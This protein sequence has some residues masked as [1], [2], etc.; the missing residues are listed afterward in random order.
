MTSQKKITVIIADDHTL[1]RRGL[2]TLLS[3]NKDVEVIAEVGDGRVAIDMTMEMQPDVVMMDLSMPNLSGFEAIRQI[4]RKAP[5]V[6]ILVLSA[7]DNEEY[8]LETIQSGADG[9]MLKDTSPGELNTAL[10]TVSSGRPYYSPAIARIAE[11]AKTAAASSFGARGSS[12]ADRLTE[13][14]REILQLI[15]ESRSHQQIAEMLHISVRTV[16]THRNNIIQKLGLHDTASLV[17]FA[18]KNGIIIL[19]R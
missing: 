1:V 7:Y 14:E 11:E 16:D 8:V 19:P 10:K 6:K 15:A 18:I 2:V 9:Y 5:K 4:K 13:R 3:L 17:T 12:I